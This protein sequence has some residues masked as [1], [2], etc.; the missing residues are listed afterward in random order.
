M[1]KDFA[2][3]LEETSS[4]KLGVKLSSVQVEQFCRFGDM[5]VFW[6]ERVNLTSIVEPREV[7]LKHFIDSL[8]L[9]RCLSGGRLAD[10]GTGAGFPGIPLKIWLPELEVVLIDSLGKRVEF[11]Q[12][13]IKELNLKGTCAVHARAEEAGRNKDYREQFDCV[14]SRAVARLPVLLEYA[15]PLLKIGG[16]FLAAKGSQVEEEVAESTS[17]LEILGCRISAVEKFSLGEEAEHR[18][19]IVVEKRR[20][21]PPAYPRKPG[22]PGKKPLG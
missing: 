1:F 11:L 21:T 9:A 7:I 17:A 5:L 12:E 10:I 13:V 20:S 8:A 4:A 19:V 22:L 14:S 16:R 6:N 15:I 3:Y 18:A 2:A